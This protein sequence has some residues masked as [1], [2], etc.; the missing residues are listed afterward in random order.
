M[1]KGAPGGEGAVD[2]NTANAPKQAK[3]KTRVFLNGWREREGDWRV[4]KEKE[5]WQGDLELLWVTFAAG[6]SVKCNLAL[7][8]SWRQDRQNVS[9]PRAY[10]R[11]RVL[12]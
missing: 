12:L 2:L 7:I 6:A 8:L 4:C 5:Y 3:K 11:V 9:Q 10:V 1:S